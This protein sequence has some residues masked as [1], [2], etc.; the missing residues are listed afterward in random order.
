MSKKKMMKAARFYKVNEPLRIEEI[1]IPVPGP[2]EVLIRMRATGVC[3]SDVHIAYEGVTPTGFLPITL[4]HEPSGE[5]AE[6]GSNATEWKE[7]DRVVVSSIVTCGKCYNCLRGRESICISKKLLGIHLNGGLAEYMV[8]PRQNLIKIPGNIPFDQASTTSDAVATPFHALVSVGKIK[9]GDSVAII[10][11]GG[12]GLHAIQLAK[13][14]GAS[15]VIAVGRTPS[16]IERAMQAGANFGVNISEGNTAKKVKE[17]TDG[18][19]VDLA[20]E[21]V[22]T[23]DMIALGADC[24]RQG[25][26]L[27]VAGLG[28]DNVKVMPPTIFVRQELEVVGSYGW[29]RREIATILQ[30]VAAGSLDISGSVSKRFKL[31]EVNTALENLR[32]RVGRP[33]RLVIVQD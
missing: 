7:G 21:L 11:L 9:L 8:A 13:L 20:I 28:P 6:I 2:D 14:A 10:G 25:G 3:G 24:L 31:E 12:L 32:D 19:G 17:I 26:K 23:Q 5:V 30:L 1:P 27:V 15:K 33:V 22:G 16:V 18:Y 4:G 29:D